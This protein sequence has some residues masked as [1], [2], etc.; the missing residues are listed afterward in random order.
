LKLMMNIFVNGSLTT[1][2]DSIK[3]FSRPIESTTK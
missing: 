3:T 2:F 1:T